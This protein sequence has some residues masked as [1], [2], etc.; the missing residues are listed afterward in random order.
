MLIQFGKAMEGPQPETKEE[1]GE[2]ARPFAILP[3]EIMVYLAPYL[4]SAQ[5]LK[6]AI[7]D[8]KALMLADK[9]MY[10][11]LNNLQDIEGFIRLLMDRFPREKSYP[12]RSVEMPA[13]LG[14]SGALKWIKAYLKEHPQEALDAVY[15]LMLNAH[16]DPETRMSFEKILNDPQFVKELIP[17][18]TS[19]SSPYMGEIEMAGLFGTPAAIEWLKAYFKEHPDQELPEFKKAVRDG[20][21]RTIEALIKAGLKPSP[22]VFIR[23]LMGLEAIPYIKAVSSPP[24]LNDPAF[25]DKFIHYFT[26]VYPRAIP[27][28]IAALFDTPGAV[29]WLRSYLEKHPEDCKEIYHRC[30]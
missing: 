16:A 20:N 5:D 17:L 8:I 23:G 29:E 9:D 13:L 15:N 6:S 19:A 11:M 3:R 28:E 10:A 4:T 18:V 7:R 26:F 30:D 14:T 2:E 1:E 24:E 12:G 25:V 21:N 27:I 22:D